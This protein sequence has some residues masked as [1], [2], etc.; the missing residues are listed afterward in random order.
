MATL[1]AAPKAVRGSLGWGTTDS[2]ASGMSSNG[3]GTRVC[4]LPV[5]P[6]DAQPIV[7][8][9]AHTAGRVLPDWPRDAWE[10]A[11]SSDGDAEWMTWER[12]S[13]SLALAAGLE[14][15]SE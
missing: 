13:R 6:P 1:P 8:D 3:G 11:N 14:P 2:G 7:R 15:N 5:A 4:S 12:L 10:F 9:K